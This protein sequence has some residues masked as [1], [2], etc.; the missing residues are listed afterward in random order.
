MAGKSKKSFEDS[1]KE[2]DGVINELE[3]GELSLEDSIVKYEKAVE[4]IEQCNKILENAQ[5]KLKKIKEGIELSP[6][7]STRSPPL[8]VSQ[9]R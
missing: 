5:G 4:L 9:S 2:L 7:C 8:L 3:N 1:L 6:I